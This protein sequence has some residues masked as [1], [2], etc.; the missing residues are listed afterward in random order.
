MIRANS[1]TGALRRECRFPSRHPGTKAAALGLAALLLTTGIPAL[2]S[3]PP[4]AAAPGDPAAVKTVTPEVPVDASGAPVG[5]ITGFTQNNNVIDLTAKAGALRLT[6][7]DEKNFRLEADPSGTFTDPANTDQGDPARTANI[8]V[9]KDKFAG[10]AVE[11][12]DGDVLVAKTAAIAVEINKAT[13]QLKVSRADGSLVFAESS[14]ITF[15][16]NSATQHLLPQDGEQ[17]IGGGM[18]N[19][20]SVHTGALINIARNFDWD[21]DGYPNAVPYYMSSKGYGVLR[22]TFARGSYD[23]GGQPTATHEEKRFDAYYFVGDYKQSLSAY[24][25][26]TGKPM[27]PP[28]YA[29]EYGDADCYNRSNPGYSSSGYGDPDGAKQRTP[30]AIKTAR[31][32]VENDMPAGWMLV[33]DGYG[34]EYQELPET[35]SN[36]EE[37]TA[38]KV[39]LWTQRSLTNQAYEVGEA[40]VRLRKLDVA[41]VGEGYR[42]ALTG[43]EAAHSGIE[44][45]SDARGTSLMVEGWAGS[46]RCG[47]QWTGD[48]SGNLDAIRWQ[49]SA[50]TGAGN[51]GLAFTTGDVDGIFGGSAESYVRDLQWKAFAPALYSMSG[52]AQTDKRPWLYGDQATA[53]NRQYLQLRQQ[54]MPFIYTLARE[55]SDTGVSMMRSMALEFPDQQW[56]YGAEA[57]N[58]FMLG[59]D[60]LVA[61][62]FT[63]TDV[64]NGIFLPAGQQWVDY[65]TG[66]LY[67]GGQILNGYSA[68]LDK[69]PVF[70]R[71]GAVVPQGIVARNASLVPEDSPITLDIYPKGRNSFSL[72]EDDKVTRQYKSGEASTQVFDVKAPDYGPGTVSV[73]IGAR[74]GE[75]NGKASARPYQLTVHAGAAP[76]E[77][78]MG[79]KLLP[80]LGDQA[81]FD[82]A[83]TG[84]YFDKAGFGTVKVKTGPIASDRTAEI[85]LKQAGPLGGA[86][87]EATAAEVRVTTG[88]QVFQNEETTVTA[89]FVNTGKSAKSNVVLTPAL[90]DGWTVK[91]AGGASA[92]TVAGGRSITATF[93][94]SPGTGAKAGP[95]TVRVSA[96]YAAADSSPQSV[97]GGN[98]IYVAYGSLAAA[99][100][101]VSVTTLAGKATGNFDGGGA[102]FAAEQLATAPIPAGGV[103]PGSTVTVAAGTPKQV[104]Y[105]WPEA[106]PDVP[107][108]VALS[109]QTIA[110]RGQ[111]THLAVLGSAAVGGGISPT[112]TLT[113]TDGTSEKQSIFF[114]NWLQPSVLNGAVVAVSEFGRNSAAGPSPEYTQYKY[115]VFSNTVRL[116]PTKELA[117]VTLPTETRVKFFDWK[118]A[119]QPLP[120]AP[121]GTVYASETPW[122]QATNGW[123]VI[124]I[125]VANK[126]SESSPDK[127]LA[128]NYTDPATGLQPTFD[129]GLGVH[130]P[131]TITY[132]LG[133][134]CTSFT[135][136]VGLESDFGG[137]IIFK[138]NADGVNKYQ[139]RTYTPGFAPESVDVD[140]TGAAYVDLVVDPSGSI[141]GAH[142]V[143]GDAKFTCTP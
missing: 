113:Y 111:G 61:P 23:F 45:H 101:A 60:F 143:W 77:V 134:K 86:S 19:G 21:D 100:N 116:N 84:W 52:W 125:N 7:L 35:V 38:L 89:E 118:V 74:T 119:S 75:Y 2:T 31:K 92:A 138:V 37:E 80:K 30:D 120:D 50:L 11:V 126:D 46:Q 95:Q 123:G 12:S 54:L 4:A 13:A 76:Q 141:N 56:S 136:Q 97:T 81:A 6:F 142:G 72:Y 3:T 59:S 104:D 10:T 57:N 1:G 41:W 24:T 115:Q 85:L 71:A 16:A 133:G 53:I 135:A 48:H 93:V 88:K 8:V 65:W 33:N 87:Q 99:Y 55:A 67:Q 22:D 131:S 49:V 66:K 47:M 40:G 90:P 34:C 20:R 105:T 14:P 112:L 42:Q 127:P 5:A 83:A 78:R 29:L 68:P 39:G 98:Q 110:V 58:Q 108:S 137:N 117:S 124:G 70:V 107:N 103:R 64:R 130:A 132:Y 140:V 106:G 26:L 109:A 114:P 121:Q 62:V 17:F 27:M 32:F 15:G 51:S 25:T 139:S 18:Q 94:V 102:T 91:T 63:Q 73:T 122:V 36:I 9:G 43:C 44:E 79:A 96:S 128:I 69:L 82:A 129:K 28:V